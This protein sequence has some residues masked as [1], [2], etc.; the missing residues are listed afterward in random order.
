MLYRMEC[1][2]HML[3]HLADNKRNTNTANCGE[4]NLFLLRKIKFTEYIIVSSAPEF[5]SV[6]RFSRYGYFAMGKMAAVDAKDIEPKTEMN[7]I[8]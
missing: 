1:P 7:L 5:V 3:P 6:M 4:E 2:H 8:E